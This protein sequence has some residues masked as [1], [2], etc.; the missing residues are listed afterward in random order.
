MAYNVSMNFF[1][2][3]RI[4]TPRVTVVIRKGSRGKYYFQA[5]EAKVVSQLPGYSSVDTLRAHVSKHFRVKV[6]VED[7]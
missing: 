7:F 2:H 5:K 6:F 1:S 4:F 3:L